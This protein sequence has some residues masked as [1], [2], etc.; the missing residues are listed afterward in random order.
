MLANDPRDLSAVPEL[1]RL[2]PEA[3]RK[4][5]LLRARI[6]DLGRAAVRPR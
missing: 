1:V 2:A 3:W 5:R 4:R 6:R